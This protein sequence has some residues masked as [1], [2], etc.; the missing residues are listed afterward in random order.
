MPE[1]GK[2]ARKQILVSFFLPC[3][4]GS[5]KSVG[6]TKCCTV[7]ESGE[8]VRYEK[9]KRGMGVGWGI[10]EEKRGGTR[11]AVVEEEKT[12]LSALC[13][14]VLGFLPLV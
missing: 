4:S 14:T 5:G 6:Q 1:S 8:L 10:W 11:Q 2:R 13:K 12:L 7:I 9:K 3:Q